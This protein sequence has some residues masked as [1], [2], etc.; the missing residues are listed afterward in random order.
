MLDFGM[1]SRLTEEQINRVVA[2]QKKQDESNANFSKRRKLYTLLLMI[3]SLA[4]IKKRLITLMKEIV[5]LIENL[6]VTMIALLLIFV[7]I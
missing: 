1:K 5:L 7:P 4:I 2:D 3:H 6:A